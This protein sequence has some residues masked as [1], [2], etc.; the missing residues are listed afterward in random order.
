MVEEAQKGEGQNAKRQLKRELGLKKEHC[1]QKRKARYKQGYR[2]LQICISKTFL[3]A[4]ALFPF[5]FQ[6]SHI[7]DKRFLVNL[8]NNVSKG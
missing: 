8:G 2:P 7:L 5:F 1:S 3:S 4:K 6:F